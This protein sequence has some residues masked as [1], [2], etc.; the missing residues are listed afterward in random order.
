MIYH[1][2]SPKDRNYDYEVLQG[3]M[4]RYIAL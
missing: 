1:K 3:I 4:Q 2:K